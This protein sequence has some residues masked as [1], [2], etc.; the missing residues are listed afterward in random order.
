[1]QSSCLEIQEIVAAFDMNLLGRQFYLL[2]SSLCLTVP[3]RIDFATQFF[4]V[5]CLY[6]KTQ[7]TQQTSIYK[8]H[9][10]KTNFNNI[11]VTEVTISSFLIAQIYEKWKQYCI[12]SA[13]NFIIECSRWYQWNLGWSLLCWCYCCCRRPII[14]NRIF[15]IKCWIINH[16]PRHT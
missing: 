5:R 6:C 15:V 10:E 9:I 11:F 16:R 14:P 13:T 4:S 7:I 1:M 8:L 2:L 12:K 3:V